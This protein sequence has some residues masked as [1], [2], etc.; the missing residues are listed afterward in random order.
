MSNCCSAPVHDYGDWNRCTA[1]GE[2]CDASAPCPCCGEPFTDGQLCMDCK[3]EVE[4]DARAAW[5][6]EDRL[7][8]AR[9]EAQMDAADAERSL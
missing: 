6:A 2:P 8:D 3:A 7:D 5:H 9:H 4:A 1:C